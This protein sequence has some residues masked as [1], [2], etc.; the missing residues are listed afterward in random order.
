MKIEG[1]P[2][3]SFEGAQRVNPG[4]KKPSFSNIEIRDIL[5]SV[6][7]LSLSFTIIFGRAYPHYFNYDTATN[8]VYWFIISVA[9]V[10]TSFLIHELGH[11]FTA[12]RYGAWSEFRMFPLGLVISLGFAL[13]SGF[14]FAAPGAVYIRGRIDTKM[15]GVI[16][17]AGPGM[18]II[19]GFIAFAI[20]LFTTGMTA[21]IFWL[22]AYLNVFLALF[23][24][25]PIPPLD[26]Y[27]IARWNIPAY[28]ITVAVAGLLFYF[29]YIM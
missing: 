6:A 21:S 19:L 23:N 1:Q 27:K 14:L 25:I 28:L 12:Q 8:Y 5:I 2:T 24:L 26:G 4:Y 29:V 13:V 16:S 11:K 10:V 7:V 20:T 17:L 3:T 22:L 9:L 18:N 15:D